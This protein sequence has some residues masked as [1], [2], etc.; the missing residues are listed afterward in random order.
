MTPKT[1]QALE[2]AKEALKFR[3]DGAAHLAC[4]AIN[5]ALAEPAPEAWGDKLD[6]WSAA[7]D[8]SHPM[9]TGAHDAY[10]QA[11]KMVGS[12]KSKGALV[13]LVCWLLQRPATRRL[14]DEEIMDVWHRYNPME[15]WSH[16]GLIRAAQARIFGDKP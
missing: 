9:K 14:T 3:S 10:T 12:R 16:L 2:L 8:A 6:E 4:Q 1:K 11:M 7:I 5:E 15:D 13:G